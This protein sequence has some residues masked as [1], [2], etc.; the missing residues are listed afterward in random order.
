MYK[1]IIRPLLF[2]FSAE[3]IHK[4]VMTGLKIAK[5]IPGAKQISHSLF[6]VK[7]IKLEREV[8]GLKFPN[9]VGLAA[10]LDKD[11]E[12]FEMLGALGFGFVEIGTLTPKGQKGNPQP[13]L[14]RI[15]ADEGLIN[16]M[17]FNNLGVEAAVEHLK[18]RNKNLII[19]GNIGK[20][21]QTAN[22]DANADYNFCFEK[23]YDHV[24]YF[25]VNVSCPNVTDLCELQDRDFL[26]S[27][28]SDI[29]KIRQSKEQKKP[30][31]LKLSPDLNNAQIDDTLSI[32]NE[33]GIDG[34]VVSNTTVT[35]ENLQTTDKE[36]EAIGRGGMSGKPIRERSTKMIKYISEKTK[37][38]LPIIGIGG[39]M[40]EQDAIEKLNAGA[41]LIQIYTGFIYEGPGLIKRINKKILET[42]TLIPQATE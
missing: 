33:T 36:I 5:W 6:S 26:V 17:G 23:L 19:G 3:T 27:L 29:I 22:A 18:K 41:H 34:L 28:L 14:F 32:V 16:R 42:N 35:R 21:T 1:R 4:F 20:N 10:G 12:A 37:G 24:D 9:P 38:K 2:S 39:I 31:L 8:F 40:N 11:A 30:I 13:R 15:K 25:T 7:N